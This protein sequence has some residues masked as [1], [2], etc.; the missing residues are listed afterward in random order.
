MFRGEPNWK[1]HV[2]NLG[3]PP[4]KISESKIVYFEWFYGDI[5]ARISAERN[6]LHIC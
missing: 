4:P 2:T 1:T 5:R 6:M 3:I